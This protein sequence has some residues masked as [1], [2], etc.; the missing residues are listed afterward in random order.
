MEDA[1]PQERI[2]QLLLGVRGD[3]D[4]RTVDSP[5]DV[6]GLD[7]R[8][9]HDVELVQ[10]V[11][12]ELEVRLVDL[13]DQEHDPSVAGERPAER[14][15]LDVLADVGDV[16]VAEPAVLKASHRVVDIQAVG[17][18][19]GRLDVPG[20]ELEAEVLGHRLCEQRLARTGLAAH[21]QGPLD[22]DRDVDRV[23]QLRRRDVGCGARETVDVLGH[24]W[25]LRVNGSRRFS[26]RRL[27]F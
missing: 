24:G 20:D 8:E 16:V 25:S 21:Q 7:H 15:E 14:P 11:V 10:E 27:V 19:G 2:G 12:G 26:L 3:D 4:D 18:F 9:L 23:A 5:V 6:A 1:P 22:R 13:V 17:R